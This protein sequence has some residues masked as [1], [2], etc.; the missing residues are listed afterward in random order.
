MTP[1]CNVSGE[2]QFCEKYQGAERKGRGKGARSAGARRDV[3]LQCGTTT[4]IHY[5][6]LLLALDQLGLKRPCGGGVVACGQ[7]VAGLACASHGLDVSA[8]VATLRARAVGWAGKWGS[9][10]SGR[11]QC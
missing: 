11:Q 1:A 4:P 10:S 8:S 5:C 7:A 3:C 9:R 6:C 2:Q